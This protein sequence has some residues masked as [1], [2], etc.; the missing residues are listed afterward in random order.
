[1]YLVVRVGRKRQQSD[2]RV[3]AALLFE[4]HPVRW[5]SPDVDADQRPAAPVPERQPCRTESAGAL[6]VNGLFESLDRRNRLAERDDQALEWLWRRQAVGERSAQD[7]L[8]AAQHVVER[9]RAVAVAVE[10]RAQAV[11]ALAT[12]A[13]HHEHE[14][15][16][17]DVVVTARVT[18]PT[19]GADARRQVQR[20]D[21]GTR[22]EA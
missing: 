21:R 8:R 6:Q 5:I 19:A 15:T 20:H 7:A 9:E 2:D 12:Q 13:A 3:A 4:M 11:G 18:H 16:H 1:M 22:T 10:P 17:V 14:I